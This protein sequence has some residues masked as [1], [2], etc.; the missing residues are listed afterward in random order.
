MQQIICSAVAARQACSTTLSGQRR[1][2]RSPTAAM[3]RYGE[4]KGLREALQG[5]SGTLEVLEELFGDEAQ[6][7]KSY[8]EFTTAPM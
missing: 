6:K 7:F 2:A 1:C 3:R 4:E 8:P 5:E